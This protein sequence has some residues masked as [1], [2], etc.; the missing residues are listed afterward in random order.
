MTTQDTPQPQ[1][2]YQYPEGLT[3]QQTMLLR[4]TEL[5]V[6]QTQDPRVLRKMVMDMAVAYFELYNNSRAVLKD[7]L[8]STIQQ[9][10]LP[11]HPEY[12]LLPGQSDS[13]E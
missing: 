10:I 4:T 8:T 13:P 5:A 7:H 1:D 11:G 9:P 12:P 3:L 2:H 6:L